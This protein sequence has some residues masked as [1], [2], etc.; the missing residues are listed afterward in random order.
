MVVGT[1]LEN[2]TLKPE[3]G[4]EKIDNDIPIKGPLVFFFCIFFSNMD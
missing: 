1:G 2:E 3:I 4:R